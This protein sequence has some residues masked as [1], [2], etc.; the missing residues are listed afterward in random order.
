MKRI[1]CTV[2]ALL[3]AAALLPS[4]AGAG[5]PEHP[6]D[7][8]YPELTLTTPEYEELAFDNGM[9]GFLI[10][11]HEIPVVEI[12]MIFG[13]SQAPREKTGLNDLA[14]WVMR[15]GGTEAWPGDRINEELEFVAANVELGGRGDYCTARVNCLKKDLGLCLEILGEVLSRPVFPEDQI[16]LRRETILERIRREND[17]PRKIAGREFARIVYGDHPKA[18]R[19]T[20]ASIGSITRDDLVAFHEAFLRPN[21]AIVG[22]AGDVTSDEIAGAFGE[23]FSGWE[24]APVTIEPEPP[25][26]LAFRP[27]LNYVEKEMNQA[28]IMIGHLGINS[29]DENA[30]AVKIMN[31]SLG[32]GAFGTR[33]TQRVRTEEG[34]AYAAYSVYQEDDENYGLFYA[35]SQTR[36]DAVGRAITLIREIIE[37]MQSEGPTEEELVHARESYLNRHAFDYENTS[38]VVQRLVLLKR[39]DRPLN[40]PELQIEKINGLTIEDVRSAARDYL[41]PEGLAIL[42]VGDESTFDQPLSNFGEVTRVEIE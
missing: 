11:D 3:L 27:S 32:G 39:K 16:E 7:L 10:E 14:A 42:V 5:R 17:D 30:E 20:A 25:L 9:T 6:R 13:T 15:N 18:W 24:A 33:I 41:H 23:A 19:A 1:A 36:S 31:F 35:S 34:L 38:M 26:E 12:F 8:E 40:E 22:V 2:L 29:G 37:E 4:V 28:V 21:N